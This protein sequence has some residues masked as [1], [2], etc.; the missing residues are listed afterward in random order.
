MAK[1]GR[2]I[3]FEGL[4]GSGQSTM[5]KL[6]AQHLQGKR[7]KVLVTKEPTKQSPISQ[8]ILDVLAKKEVVS[9]E[10][11]QEF[12]AKDREWHLENIVKPAL[13]QGEDVISDRY[14]FSSL[15]YGLLSV[16]LEFLEDLNRKFL[17]PDAIFFLD[18]KPETCIKRIESRGLSA[19]LFEELQKLQK[20][21]KNYLSIFPK[22]PNVYLIDAEQGIEETF[23]Q[24][25]EITDNKLLK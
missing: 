20:V 13:S 24:I 19:T 15:A 18:A 4:D 25:K 2:F 23:A 14:F 3:V 21:Y 17:L 9:P 10:E 7:G 16:P 5:S 22:Y 1:K 12:F 6:L 11:L 8:T